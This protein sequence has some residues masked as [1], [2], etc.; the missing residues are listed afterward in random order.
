V[1][2]LRPGG[3]LLQE[4]LDCLWDTLGRRLAGAGCGFHVDPREPADAVERRFELHQP[5]EAQVQVR[6]EAR[7]QKVVIARMAVVDRQSATKVLSPEG[8]P[9][10]LKEPAPALLLDQ[11]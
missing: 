10:T 6:A 3:P 11:C 2:G 5:R 8:I 9:H 1:N 4:L 7:P